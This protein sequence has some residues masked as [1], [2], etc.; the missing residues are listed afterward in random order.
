MLKSHRQRVDAGFGAHIRL[1]RRRYEE[2]NVTSGAATTNR[3]TTGPGRGAVLRPFV[4]GYAVNPVALALLWV[5]RRW[6]LVAPVHLW[7]YFVVLWGAAR[8]VRLTTALPASA[9]LS[10]SDGAATTVAGCSTSG[11]GTFERA[12]ISAS[13]EFCRRT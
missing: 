12:A 11:T 10:R 5:L 8:R 9:T 7:V 13:L 6:N 4:L 3:S 1:R 2:V